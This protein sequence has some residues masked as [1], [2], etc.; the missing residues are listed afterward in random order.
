MSRYDKE[1]Y[2][3]DPVYRGQRLAATNR[4]Y[5]VNRAKINAR[6]R[7]KYAAEPPPPGESRR[8]R[9]W[10]DYGLT[11]RDFDAM[12]ARQN[13]LCAICRRRPR[14]PLFVDHSHQTHMLRSLLCLACNSGLGNFGD[15]PAL[16]RAAADYAEHWQR[17]HARQGPQ[18]MIPKARRA[19]LMTAPKPRKR[20]DS[21]DVEHRV[22][23]RPPG[24]PADA[25]RNPGGAQLP[26]QRPRRAGGGQAAA[27]RA[28]PRAKGGVRR[29]VGD[30]GGP[31]QDRRQ[32]PA[33]RRRKR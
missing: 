18:H 27:G 22:V 15:D 8:R 26:A 28:P 32:E 10:Q 4:W 7:L 12:S 33:E 17:I 21:H 16:L 30:Q 11:L 9:L 20:K 23:G 13:G 6:R 24:Q 29:R 25:S 5:E 19:L 31:R 14:K 1:R 3:T 2:A